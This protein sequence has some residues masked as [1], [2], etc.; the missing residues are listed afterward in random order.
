[1]EPEDTRTGDTRAW[2]AKTRQVLRRVE[3]LLTAAPPDVEGA[4]FHC[5]GLGM[6]L[7]ELLTGIETEV[8]TPISPKKAK[9]E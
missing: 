3:I 8:S 4:L 9:R 2:L 7:S 6:S 1:M 5:R